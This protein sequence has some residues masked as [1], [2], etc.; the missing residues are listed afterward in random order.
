M[1]D[2]DTWPIV[3][4]SL[5]GFFILFFIILMSVIA[6]NQSRIADYYRCPAKGVAGV[7]GVAGGDG[8]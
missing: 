4:I 1:A 3:A 2:T 5:G 7:A 8:W 6:Y